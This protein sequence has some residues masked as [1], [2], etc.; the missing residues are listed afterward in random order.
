MVIPYVESM[1]T[2]GKAVEAIPILERVF[3]GVDVPI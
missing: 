3:P 1:L 2:P